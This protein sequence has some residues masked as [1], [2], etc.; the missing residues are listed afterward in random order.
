MEDKNKVKA[1]DI[2][3]K[4]LAAVKKRI[5]AAQS[6]GDVENS[7]VYSFNGKTW[8]MAL[9]PS[10]MTQ[11][12]LLHLRDFMLK[13]PDDADADETFI[14]TIAKYVQVNGGNVNVDI[15]EYGELE[16]MKLAYLDGLLLPLSLGGGLAVEKYMEAA[17]ANLK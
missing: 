5:E 9:P 16:V 12:R 6:T 10:V 4:Y 7:F 8:V 3:E 2:S 14:R 11:K 1:K 17:V 13:N 15:L